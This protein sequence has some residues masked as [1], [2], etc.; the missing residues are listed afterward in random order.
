M[1]IA[2]K[3]GT[4]LIGPHSEQPRPYDWTDHK[5]SSWRDYLSYHY[6]NSEF[7]TRFWGNIPEAAWEIQLPEWRNS[8]QAFVSHYVSV[9]SDVIDDTLINEDEYKGHVSAT[10]GAAETD[11]DL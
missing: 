5:E 3:Q 4:G 6:F 11:N 8:I 7:W 1:Y 10:N 2:Y 9:R